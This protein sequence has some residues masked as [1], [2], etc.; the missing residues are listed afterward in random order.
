MTHWFADNSQSFERAR[1]AKGRNLGCL[2]ERRI[3]AAMIRDAGRKAQPA[4]QEA[5]MQTRPVAMAALPRW[6]RALRALSR[7][8]A[9][10]ESGADLAGR[11]QD[12]VFQTRA[13]SARALPREPR[14]SA[15][16]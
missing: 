7:A 12:T 2:V 13:A 11:E 10:R 9:P 16:K 1:L 14:R 8:L 15:E 5:N 4:F 3:G 6:R